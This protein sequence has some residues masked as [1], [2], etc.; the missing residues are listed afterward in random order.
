M[1]LK[2]IMYH[3]HIK[4]V[5]AQGGGEQVEG[6]QEQSVTVGIVN[7]EFEVIHKSEWFWEKGGKYW[8]YSHRFK[9]TIKNYVEHYLK[10]KHEINRIDYENELRFLEWCGLLGLKFT[11][12]EL[13]VKPEVWINDNDGW[14]SGVK[15]V[16]VASGVGATA[17]LATGAT[18]G[19]AAG[20]A[21]PISV[22]TAAATGA[23]IGFAGEAIEVITEQ[24]KFWKHLSKINIKEDK[25]KL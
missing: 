25:I 8:D 19:L 16:L 6:R 10:C 15:N 14:G 22:P 2:I 13:N 4:N 23:L 12:Q 7:I 17:G 20:P 1:V 21:A 24:I 3:I 11:E 18:I 9:L 5:G